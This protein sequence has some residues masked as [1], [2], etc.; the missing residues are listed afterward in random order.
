MNENYEVNELATAETKALL[1]AIEIIIEL[2]PTK[3]EAKE[4]IK[5]I[6]NALGKEKEPTEHRDK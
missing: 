5:E 6:E 1:K 4:R 3:E 2:S